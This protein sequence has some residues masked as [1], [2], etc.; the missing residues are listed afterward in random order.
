MGAW[1]PVTRRRPA[2]TARSDLS[3]F[4]AYQAEQP[5][6]RYRL[7]TNESPYAPP[8]AVL[9]RVVAHLGEAQLNRYP[10]KDAAGL[11]RRVAEL[12]EWPAPGLWI[13]NGS[14]EVFLHLLLA[15][16]GPGR[17]VLTFE[18]TYA[19]H[20]TIPRVTG[21]RVEQTDRT[22]DFLIDAGEA[23]ER[24]RSARPELVM[25]CSP[26]NPSGGCEP[27][28]T[29]RLL[30]E[31]AP[32]LVV[33]DEAYI[34]FASE[35]DS[36]R[37]LLEEHRNLVLVKTLSKAWSLAGVRLGYMLAAPEVIAEMAPVRIPYH[38]STITQAAGEAALDASEELR[39]ATRSIAAERDRVIV[40][41]QAMGIETFPSRANFVLFRVQDASFVWKALLAK[42]V[43]VRHYNGHP[44]L[45]G[46]LR[47][48]AGRREENDAFLDALR[49]V[50][51]A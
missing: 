38:L 30:L 33:V 40:A 16:G 32:G 28:A 45:E 34:E 50:L 13:A 6:A 31:S 44:L 7:N 35:D 17:T 46:C 36:V 43:L 3:S 21:T 12:N 27:L 11:Y 18:P 20:S 9:E 23:V 42:D 1:V 22:A 29:V 39:A 51:D 2:L 49:E 15:F 14:N 5:P 37:P 10:D 47:V 24:V 8:D 26:N 19:L 48:T 4:V 25:V 41:L